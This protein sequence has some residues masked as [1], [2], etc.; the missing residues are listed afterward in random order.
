[1]DYRNPVTHSEEEIRV[2]S[3]LIWER[4]CGS[5]GTSEDNWLRARA[6]LDTEFDTECVT[7]LSGKSTTFV[8]P[9]LM[10]S[11]LPTIN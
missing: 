3:Y 10:I 6:E 9:L 5:E 8:L 11:S 1:M 4:E 2:R 7:S